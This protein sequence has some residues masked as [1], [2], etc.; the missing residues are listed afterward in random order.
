MQPSTFAQYDHR[1]RAGIDVYL[2][3]IGETPLLSAGEELRLARLAQAGDAGARDHIIRANLRLV[4]SIAKKYRHSGVDINDLI[5]EGNIGL[6]I[7]IDKFNPAL[8]H[9]FTTYATWWV[10]QAITRS[11]ADKARLIRLP[12]HLAE[13]I[14]S[15]RRVQ[16]SAGEHAPSVADIALALG[17]DERQV[18]IALA[19][20]ATPI[21]LDEPLDDEPGASELVEVVPDPIESVEQQACARLLAEDLAAALAQLGERE[22]VVLTLRYGLDGGKPRTLEVVGREFG[23][24]R[25]RARQIEAEALRKLRHPSVGAALRGWLK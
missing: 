14:A 11:I 5:Q 6:L 9:R 17:L 15:V 1:D 4:V 19:N 2:R 25:E 24:T 8:G 12:V 3:Q 21:S 23:I 10:R 18:E 16:A 22:R 7:A 20:I 13:R